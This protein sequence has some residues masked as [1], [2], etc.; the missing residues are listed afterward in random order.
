M[1]GKLQKSLHLAS[2]SANDRIMYTS[3]AYICNMC[4]SKIL[5]RMEKLCAFKFG[6]CHVLVSPQQDLNYL[7]IHCEISSFIRYFLEKCGVSQTLQE[8]WLKCGDW[9]MTHFQDCEKVF[10]SSALSGH[11]ILAAVLLR[12][13]KLVV[14]QGVWESELR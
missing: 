5:K 3:M 1:H 8:K 12:I 10:H 7:F 9:R 6:N 11:D 14:L 13:K 2:R 4:G